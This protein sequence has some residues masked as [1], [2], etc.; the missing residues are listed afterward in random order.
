[1]SPSVTG[2]GAGVGAGGGDSADVFIQ[3]T[4]AGPSS[5][6]PEPSY[7]AMLLV[8]MAAVIFVARRKSAT[9]A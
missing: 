5:T 7:T 8:G 1:V 6:V 3:F 2:G 9:A 4:Y